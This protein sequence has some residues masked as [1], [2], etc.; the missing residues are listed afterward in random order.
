[1]FISLSSSVSSGLV[2]QG[3]T[4]KITACFFLRLSL[5]LPHLHIYSLPP[6]SFSISLFLSEPSWFPIRSSWVPESSRGCRCGVSRTW[7]WSRFPRRCMAAS[8]PGTPTCCS[9]PPR[10]LHTTYT[11]G[12]VRHMD[13]YCA[14]SE[15]GIML[16]ICV[17]FIL[18][19]KKDVVMLFS[20]QEHCCIA[21]LR[22][23]H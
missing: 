13:T 7:T 8:S 6:P 3:K 15:R 20:Q 14:P 22:N 4:I 17:L 10:L 2:L 1:M 18:L 21:F 5:G 12:W 23:N 11:C 9:S 19:Y 16:H